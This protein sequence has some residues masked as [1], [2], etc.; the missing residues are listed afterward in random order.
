MLIL[1]SLKLPLAH[2]EQALSRP[3]GLPWPKAKLVSPSNESDPSSA[4]PI[5]RAQFSLPYPILD[6]KLCQLEGT[7]WLQ[8][9]FPTLLMLFISPNDK[10]GMATFVFSGFSQDS[11]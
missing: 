6:L 2:M 3:E 5:P 9:P 1:T 4:P 10:S 11:L 7:S 8:L